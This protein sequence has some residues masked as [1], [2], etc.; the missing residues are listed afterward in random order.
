MN[1]R[2]F[3]QQASAGL[4]ASAVI[5]PHGRPNHARAQL[6]GVSASQHDNSRPNILLVISD[7]QSWLHTSVAGDRVVRTPAFDRIAREG[8]LFTHAFCASPS[9]TPSRGALLTGQTPWRLKDNGN[10]WSTLPKEFPVYPDLLEHAGYVV[11]HTGKGW[12]PGKV[13][14]GGRTRNPA[15]PL[16]Q[17]FSRF[18]QSA[19][20]HRP[21][22]FWFGSRDPHRPYEKGTGLASGKRLEDVEVPPFLPDMPEIRSDILDYYFEIER[23]DRQLKQMLDLLDRTGRAENTLVV[24]TS[25]NGMPFP[26]AKANLYDYGTHM[27][28]AIRWPAKIRS[29]RSIADF[30]GL[31]DLAPTFLEAAGLKPPTDMTGSSLLG[32]LVSDKPAP[33]DP[34]RDKAFFGRERHAW[35]RAGGL[36]YP[37]RAVRTERH[38]YIRNFEA[39][40]HPAGDPD[41]YGNI[42]P[43]PTKSIMRENRQAK[44]VSHLFQLAFEKRPAE[45]LYDLRTDPAQMQN[46]AR[47]AEYADVRRQLSQELDRWMSSTKDPRG[48]GQGNPWDHYPFHGNRDMHHLR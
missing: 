7:D 24:V 18:L 28:L 31:T 26:R 15:G 2:R 43:G 8:A 34:S 41:I 16:F 6:A 35:C 13:E 47:L 30:V 36:G 9:C 23:F 39:D 17:D 48:S 46:I 11:G 44:R 29:G 40:R 4:L 25:D 14:A 37:A 38:L 5:N 45:E 27:P 10:L 22:C 1:R 19:P 42:D 20:T 12:A 33:P 21:F 3:L 32:R